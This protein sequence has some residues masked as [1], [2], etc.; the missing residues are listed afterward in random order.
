M[1]LTKRI[2]V[3]FHIKLWWLKLHEGDASSFVS[4]ELMYQIMEVFPKVN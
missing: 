2:F 4:E 1:F 3:I